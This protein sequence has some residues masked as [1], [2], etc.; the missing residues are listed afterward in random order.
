MVALIALVWAGSAE[1]SVQE[2][3]VQSKA[4]FDLVW[5]VGPEGMQ[6]GDGLRAIDPSFHGMRWAKWGYLSTDPQD[7]S[8]LSQPN[9]GPSGGLVTGSTSGDAILAVS[10]NTN[11]PGI[12]DE[13]WTEVLLESGDLLEGDTITLTMGSGGE[14][15]GLQTSNRTMVEVPWPVL[16]KLDGSWEEVEAP[17]FD[18]VSTKA[19]E[20]FLVSLP[21]QALPGEEVPVLVA[22]LD[23][24]GN[25]IPG[26]DGLVLMGD[27]SHFFEPADQGV[28]RTTAVFDEEG[29]HRLRVSATGLGAESNPI[30]V[31]AEPDL[32]GIYW[33]DLHTHHGHSWTD[34]TGF[35]RDLN[36][37]YA[38]DVV[39]LQVGCESVKASPHELGWETLWPEL[40][41]TCET[42][43]SESYL[44]LLCFEWMGDENSPG[45]EGHH[46]VYYDT[47]TGSLAPN[48]T[49]GLSGDDSLW[50]YMVEAEAE[51]G[52][53]SISVPHAPVY[54]GYNWRDRNDELRPV[55]EIY[56][57]WGDSSPMNGPQSS[58]Y[59]GL[60]LGHR[61]GLIASSDNHDGWL[62]N[63]WSEKSTWGGLAA[64]V[65]T[66]LSRQSLFEALDTRS[67]YATTGHRPL[68][69]FRVEETETGRM[70]WEVVSKHPTFSWSY[71]AESTHI[72]RVELL[73]VPANGG[74]SVEVLAVWTPA[75]RDAEASFTYDWEGEERAVWLHVVEAE[76]QAW[77]SPIWLT[78]SCEDGIDIGGLCDGDTAQDSAQFTLRTDTGTGEQPECGG[79]GG[80][81]G[82]GWVLVVLAAAIQRKEP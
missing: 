64:F 62:G 82:V 14:A 21:S 15:C 19:I 8:P 58:V 26:Y 17:R 46:N 40:Q 42:H 55:A 71:S 44:A 51:T 53:R 54:T 76:N 52:A 24:L 47:C 27:Q 4:T 50:T 78:R 5:T 66:D 30:L 25:P 77:S 13:G 18:F 36:H 38:R 34:E 2:I 31:N 35:T 23:E 73:S 20:R 63:R 7:C 79:C 37:E 6:A 9:A 16:V 70:G 10:R 32:Y 49:T 59:D 74:G 45:N 3:E 57:E 39:G 12:H 33:G 80:P 11:D 60:A 43:T 81:G 48:S 69:A 22:A 56:S 29:V 28:W 41:Q 75:E 1:L 68:M 61:M 72:T 65:A 67:T